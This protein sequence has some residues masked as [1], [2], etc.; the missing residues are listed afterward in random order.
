[1]IVIDFIAKQLANITS[2]ILCRH[3]RTV[4]LVVVIKVEVR[5]RV[6]K[7]T[8]SV[9][10]QSL[11]YDK[12]DEFRRKTKLWSRKTGKLIS[13]LNE[14]GIEILNSQLD[15]Q[16]TIVWIWCRSQIALQ[17]IQELYELNELKYVFFDFI[18]LQ[19]PADKCIESMVVDIDSNQFTRTAGKFSHTIL[20]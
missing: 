3:L 13:L 14:N 8:T 15:R 11:F 10:T 19:P 20:L 16:T 6:A 17:K 9:E 1:M 12:I 2:K 7:Y 18:N 4:L 5:Y